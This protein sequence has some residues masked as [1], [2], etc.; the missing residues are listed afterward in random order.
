[1]DIDEKV[2]LSEFNANWEILF[3]DERKLLQSSLPDTHIEHVGST[4]VRGMTAKPIIDIMLGVLTYPPSETMI[5][6]L[7]GLGYYHFGEHNTSHARLYFVK[8]G[9]TN[10]NIHVYEYKGQQWNN[11]IAF[12]NYLRNHQDAASEYSEI[13]KQIIAKGTNSMLDYSKEKA[14]F[15]SKTIRLAA[16][17]GEIND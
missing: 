11:Q 10:F 13:K 9:L 1:M 4:S 16:E 17:Q 3:G 6:G 5:L 12:R 14:D 2:S 8:R 15:I 7:E